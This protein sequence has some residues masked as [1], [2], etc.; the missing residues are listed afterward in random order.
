M[1]LKTKR[2]LIRPM[3]YDDKLSVYAYLKDKETM[4]FFVEGTYSLEKVQEIIDKNKLEETKYSVLLKDSFEVIGHLSF[5]IL[6]MKDTYE[7]GWVFNKLFHNKGYA[8]EAAKAM[9]NYGFYTLKMHCLC[10]TCQPENIASTRIME[11]LNMRLEST[12]LKCI[13][14]KDDIWWDELS[15]AILEEEFKG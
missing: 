11:K 9:L 6:G 12:S 15:Y 13:Y 7:I 1:I 10:A 5:H 3:N 4:R 14:Y 2:L 8:T